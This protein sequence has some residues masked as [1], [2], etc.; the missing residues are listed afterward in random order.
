M[1]EEIKTM[2]MPHSLVL[3]D[4]KLLTVSGVS[5]VDS[6]DETTE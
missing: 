1:P 3:D 2:S 6:F 4:R 5:D